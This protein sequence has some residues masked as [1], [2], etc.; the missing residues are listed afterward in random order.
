ME[1]GRTLG[2]A[3]GRFQQL[4]F[5]GVRVL[6]ALLLDR[7]VFQN[8]VGD[9]PHGRGRMTRFQVVEQ[10][11]LIRL[12]EATE[13]TRKV[14]AKLDRLVEGFHAFPEGV[15]RAARPD[16]AV[17]APL[18]DLVGIAFDHPLAAPRLGRFHSERLTAGE[19]QG[20][21]ADALIALLEELLADEVGH[22]RRGV[23]FIAQ[24]QIERGLVLDRGKVDLVVFEGNVRQEVRTSPH[25][26]RQDDVFINIRRQVRLAGAANGPVGDKRF[27]A[28]VVKAANLAI[29][30]IRLA[31]KDGA[32]GRGQHLPL[33]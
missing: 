31:G 6:L 16:A 11:F 25:R 1:G 19:Q 4:L 33:D 21:E 32:A 9:E 17:V 26:Q 22:R 8:E 24:E 20:A 18:V 7:E 15:K 28:V 13:P 23:V 27:L 30:G 29:L 5:Q 3:D 12:A 10:A 2:E 14:I